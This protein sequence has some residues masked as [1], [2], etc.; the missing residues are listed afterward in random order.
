MRMILFVLQVRWEAMKSSDPRKNMISHLIR[1]T[2][3]AVLRTDL[4]GGRQRLKLRLITKLL[5]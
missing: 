4:S 2:M 3:A 1:M 5:L